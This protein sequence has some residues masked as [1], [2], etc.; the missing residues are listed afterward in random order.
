MTAAVPSRIQPTAER[1]IQPAVERQQHARRGDNRIAVL[2]FPDW[3]VQAALLEETRHGISQK[4]RLLHWLVI[5]ASQRAAI[6]PAVMG[7]AV[8]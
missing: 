6:K 1:S 8:V 4:A 5:T 3:P 7:C 2:W